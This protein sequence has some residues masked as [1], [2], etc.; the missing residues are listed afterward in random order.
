M[1]P[2]RLDRIMHE[3]EAL[4]N[5]AD[6]II[7]AHVN[8][9]LAYHPELSSWGVAKINLIARPAGATLNRIEALK[10]VRANWKR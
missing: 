1:K 7:D 5:D 6:G 2:T 9:Y 3:L 8:E 10:I 4:Q